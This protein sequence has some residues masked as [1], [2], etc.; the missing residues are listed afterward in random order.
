MT[1]RMTEILPSTTA[2]SVDSKRAVSKPKGAP[3][4]L[5]AEAKSVAWNPAPAE[6]RR[7]AE[8]MPN[9]RPTEFGNV[10]VATRV[11]SRSKLSTFVATDTPE[12]HSDQT[13][14]RAEYERMARLQNDYIRTRDMLIVEGFIGN[15]PQFR[16]AARLIIEKANANIAG[17]QQHLYYPMTRS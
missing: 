15:D 6:L 10:N 2:P 7:F 1:D 13:I 3:K 16:V 12:H 17:M 4:T 14:T 8:E 5:P 11:V 9:C